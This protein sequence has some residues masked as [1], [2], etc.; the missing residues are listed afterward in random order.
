MPGC[1]ASCQP[2]IIGLSSS[3]FSSFPVSEFTSVAWLR[4]NPAAA[5][6]VGSSVHCAKCR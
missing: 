1:N 5:T 2:S 4:S 3:S 6:S